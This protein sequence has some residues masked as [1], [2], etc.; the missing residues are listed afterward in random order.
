MVLY[1]CLNFK[2][3]ILVKYIVESHL[4]SRTNLIENYVII[5][6]LTVKDKYILSEHL[7]KRLILFNQEMLKK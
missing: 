3:A 4:I 5:A 2:E 6:S 7:S 1:F